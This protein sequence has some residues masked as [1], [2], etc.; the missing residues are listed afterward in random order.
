MLYSE[1]VENR[2]VYYLHKIYLIFNVW[3][4]LNDNVVI[5]G[6]RLF[7]IIGVPN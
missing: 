7:K 3:T 1:I 4:T 6:C 2:V 5:V